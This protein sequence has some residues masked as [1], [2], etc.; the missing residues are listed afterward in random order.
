MSNNTYM[1]TKKRRNTRKNTREA[2]YMY[3]TRSSNIQRKKIISFHYYL[4]IPPPPPPTSMHTHTHQPAVA[5]MHI[6]SNLRH[7]PHSHCPPL[8]T[9]SCAQ[10]HTQ[11]TL[12]MYGNVKGVDSDDLVQDFKHLHLIRSW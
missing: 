1:T 3:H 9:H 2:M 4:P 7:R 11:H 5:G 12:S 6:T 8:H 10:T